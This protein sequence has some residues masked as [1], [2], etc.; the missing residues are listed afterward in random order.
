MLAVRSRG[1]TALCT[2]GTAGGVSQCS[3]RASPSE[4]H[5]GLGGPGETEGNG[6][7]HFQL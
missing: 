3:R 4:G 2:V 6:G 1:G 5:Q 7:Q